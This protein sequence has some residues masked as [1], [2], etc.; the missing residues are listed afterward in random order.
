MA[1]ARLES[2]GRRLSGA[3]AGDDELFGEG[4]L[5]LAQQDP[6]FVGD[7]GD[8]IANPR[9]PATRDE[10]R[11]DEKSKRAD[12]K[13]EG[14]PRPRT[15]RRRRGRRG[16]RTNLLF[17]VLHSWLERGTSRVPPRPRIICKLCAPS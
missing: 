1:S 12:D 2:L 13:A 9:D 7:V 17:S 5:E 11:G 15:R 3:G 6:G 10:W 4:P 8:V 14:E 16:R